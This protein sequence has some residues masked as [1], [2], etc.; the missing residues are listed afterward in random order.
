MLDTSCEVRITVRASGSRPPPPVGCTYHD[1]A[2]CWP[3]CLKFCLAS[4]KF[5]L[6]C[7][8]VVVATNWASHGDSVTVENS[9]DLSVTY[10]PH[11]ND[12]CD[13]SSHD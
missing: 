12:R 10:S 13:F 11:D 1:T 3:V 5:C 7:S 2:S 9:M 4:S 8:E 6:R